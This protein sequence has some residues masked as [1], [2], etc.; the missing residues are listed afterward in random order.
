M[1]E[2]RLYSSLASLK[3]YMTS[4]S[5]EGCCGGSTEFERIIPGFALLAVSYFIFF[6]LNNSALL[7]GG[8]RRRRRDVDSRPSSQSTFSIHSK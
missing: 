6:L 5:S 4:Y 8:G 2:D 1:A 3:S 7:G